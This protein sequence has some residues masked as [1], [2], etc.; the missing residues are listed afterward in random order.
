MTARVASAIFHVADYRYSSV[1]NEFVDRKIVLWLTNALIY[2]KNLQ[3]I[4][5][6]LINNFY[7]N[8]MHNN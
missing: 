2:A 6:F 3:Q 1:P 4:F 5:F 8:Y 7:I